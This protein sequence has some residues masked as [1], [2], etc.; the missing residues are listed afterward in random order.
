MLPFYARRVELQNNTLIGRNEV[1]KLSGLLAVT[2]LVISFCAEQAMLGQTNGELGWLQL[3][4]NTL[5]GHGSEFHQADRT[6]GQSIGFQ[7]CQALS[8]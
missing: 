7:L 3:D 1:E 2:L 4:D 8:F 6:A 5:A